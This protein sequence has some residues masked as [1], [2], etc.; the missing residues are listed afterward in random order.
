MIPGLI[1]SVAGRRCRHGGGG[2]PFADAYYYFDAQDGGSIVGNGGTP[3][4]LIS[5]GSVADGANALARTLSQDTE[6]FRPETDGAVVKFLTSNTRLDLDSPIAQSGWV[7]VGT[8]RGTFAYKTNSLQM[9]QLTLFGSRSASYPTTGDLYGIVLL[10]ADFSPEQIQAAREAMIAKGAAD[11]VVGTGMDS[12]FRIR[13]DI[14]EF[15]P[16]DTSLVTSMNSTW[17][18][19]DLTSIPL[20]D[21]SA[22]VDL[23]SAWE[24]CRNLTSMP[25]LD[26]SSCTNLTNTWNMCGLTSFPLVDTSNVTVMSRTWQSNNLT[27]FPLI[28]TSNVTTFFRAWTGNANLSSFP[29]LN[30]SSLINAS[31]AWS[32]TAIADF[33]VLDFTNVTAVGDAWSSI[34]EMTSFPF[35]NTAN[36]TDFNRAWQGCRG[37][38][39]FP[40]L[41]T[42]N[43]QI[44]LRSW[45]SC[46]SL[47][48]FPAIDTGNATNLSYAWLMCNALV[49]F[50]LL[51]VSK[52]TTFREAWRCANLENFPAGMFDNWIAT[53]ASACFYRA[54]WG[55]SKLTATSVE[56]ILNSINTSGVNAPGSTP[57]I[58][59]DYDVT[60]G[61]PDVSS[62]V[63]GLNSRGWTVVLNGTLL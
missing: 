34:T 52:S 4:L 18:S 58:T 41:N 49:S 13:P 1:S 19:A 61:T 2:T 40:L 38:T 8:S 55:T 45:A 30:T 32:G 28:D 24:S 42:S 22:V 59:I 16:I 56:N 53:P 44:F 48:S 5:W 14:V 27:S 11:A 25:A 51:N 39:S 26:L 33:P 21:T 23:T 17:R 36:V 20:I 31:F 62:A 47:E 10:P 60:T 43:G 50:P 29:L 3:N 63:S 54:W 7:V 35:L 37:L 46:D 9:T 15:Y 57:E 6:S 12:W